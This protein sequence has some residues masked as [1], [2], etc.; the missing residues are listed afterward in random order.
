MPRSGGDAAPR[1]YV[2]RGQWPTGTLRKDAP[3]SAR[4]GQVF[5]VRLQQALKALGDPSIRL[6]AREAAVSRTTIERTLDGEVL[7]DFGAVARL[8]DW[9]GVDLW[10]GPEIRAGRDRRATREGV[11]DQG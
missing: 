7:P 9:L 5:V 6:V 1:T 10:P 3:A 8:E 4:Y 11:L 2:A